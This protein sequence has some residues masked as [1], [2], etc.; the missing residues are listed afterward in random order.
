MTR[1]PL[2]A[3]LSEVEFR[4]WYWLKFELAAFA[5]ELRLSPT[6]LKQDI[7]ERIAAHLSCRTPPP[8]NRK[9]R[10]A[11]K[12]PNAFSLD[13][14]VGEGW[15]CTQELRSFFESQCGSGFRF[16]APLREFIASGNGQPLSAAVALY[17]NSLRKGPQPI[18]AQFEY[19]RHMREFKALNPDGTHAEAVAAWWLKRGKP[20]A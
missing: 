16:N 20:S 19:N 7:A 8:T 11:A 13:T 17:V 15:R 12:M 3:S 14:R 18:A 10:R 4:R 6:G 2:T 9:P 5:R 1:P